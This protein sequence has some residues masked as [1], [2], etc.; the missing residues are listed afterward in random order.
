MT[1]VDDD[2]EVVLTVKVA[3]VAPAGMFTLDGTVATEGLLLESETT[4]PALGAGPLSVAV[5]VEGLPPVTLEGLTLNAER[6]GGTDV[7]VLPSSTE[8]VKAWR[9]ATARSGAES[10]LNSLTVTYTGSLSTR[11]FCAA[12]K[13]PS[14]L[15]SSTETVL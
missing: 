4:A 8:I 7:P 13:V 3:L 11:K 12:W 5:P 6:V 1:E 10:P 9:L 14:P 2:T 15:P